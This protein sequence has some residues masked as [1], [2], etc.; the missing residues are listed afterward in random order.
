MWAR[1]LLVSIG[2]LGGTRRPRAIPRRVCKAPTSRISEPDRKFHPGHY[3]AIGK[4][5]GAKAITK[6]A[7]KGVT[8]VQLRYRWA[9]L[10]PEEGRY[11]FS[12]I[13]RDLAAA[14]RAGLQLVVMVE[15]KSFDHEVP[16]PAYLQDKHT[17]ATRNRGFTARALGSVRQRPFPATGGKARSAI[18][19]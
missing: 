16:T 14:K 5:E 6:A 1:L 15:D 12:A 13:A 2:L 11:D 18:R 4:A 9:I 8:G 7:N 19:L 17:V 10:E 3:V